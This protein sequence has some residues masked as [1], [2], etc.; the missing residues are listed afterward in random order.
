MK[1]FQLNYSKKS[2]KE[3]FN[4]LRSPE[5]IPYFNVR[6]TY[7]S[8]QASVNS[9]EAWFDYQFPENKDDVIKTIFNLL[10]NN[11]GKKHC[12]WLSGESGSGKS[13]VFSSLTT[14]FLNIGSVGN[15]N[16]TSEFVYSNVPGSK[17]ILMDEPTIPKIRFNDFK[18]FFAGQPVECNIKH[19]HPVDSVESFWILLSNPGDIFDMTDH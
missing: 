5:A 10:T 3:Y 4:H 16:S 19:K 12:L 2:I 15:L 11:C 8:I 13:T 18:N 6:F 7:K 14:L 9:L 1:N 17:I